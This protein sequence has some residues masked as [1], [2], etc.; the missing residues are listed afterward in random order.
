MEGGG[1][2]EGGS[3]N[4]AMPRKPMGEQTLRPV[5]LKQIRNAQVHQDTS[6]KID[7]ADVTQVTF[8]AVIRQVQEMTTN[9]SYTMEDGTGLIEVR[10]WVEQNETAEETQQRRE[11]VPDLYVRVYGRLNNFNN[12]ISCVAFAIRPITDYNEIS[13][14]F[15]DAIYTHVTFTRPS[16]GT[17]VVMGQAS[18]YGGMDVGSGGS[19]DIHKRVIDTIKMYQDREEGASVDQIIQRMQ[20]LYNENAVREAID[21][22]TNEGH[23]YTTIDD[24]HIKSTESF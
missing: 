4:A 15:L 10:R 12:R 23:C 22:L 24:Y 18:S 19:S 6:F 8:V 5:T 7:G 9:Y 11:L 3:N 2:M 17:D 1:F 16:S 20:G 14:H 13:Y 21:Y